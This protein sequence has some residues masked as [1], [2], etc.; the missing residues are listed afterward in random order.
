M[1]IFPTHFENILSIQI[2][3]TI[4]WIKGILKIKELEWRHCL[5]ISHDRP[6]EAL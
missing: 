2:V 6:M 3:Y 4:L 1:S 5:K